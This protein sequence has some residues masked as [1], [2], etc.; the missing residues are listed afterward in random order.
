[1]MRMA[2]PKDRY[3]SPLHPPFRF[4][5]QKAETSM[6]WSSFRGADQTEPTVALR[7]KVLGSIPQTGIASKISWY[8]DFRYLQTVEGYMGTA[9][10]A[11]PNISVSISCT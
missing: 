5:W 9:P 11:K 4:D 1:M 10:S 3:T 6:T 2:K 7:Q 8:G